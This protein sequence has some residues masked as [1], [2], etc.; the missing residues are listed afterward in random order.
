[1]NGREA[2]GEDGE[3]CALCCALG[4]QVSFGGEVGRVIGCG[5]DYGICNIV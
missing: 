5:M 4:G 1:M 2:N 3:R